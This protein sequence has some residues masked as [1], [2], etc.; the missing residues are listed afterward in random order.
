MSA[1]L[2][3]NTTKTSP[4]S[5]LNNHVKKA[6][7]DWHKPN[8]GQSPLAGL[9]IFREF[10]A[11]VQMNHRRVTNEILLAGIRR[12]EQTQEGY[13]TYLQQR[14]INE[15]S[16]AALARMYKISQ[17]VVYDRQKAALEWLSNVLWD[18]EQE[19]HQVH[20]AKMLSRLEPST[21]VNLIGAEG[22]QTHLIEKISSADAPHILLL[23]GIGGIGKTSLTDRTVRRCIEEGVVD[24][25]GWV[26][27][28][29]QQLTLL[30][31][32]EPIEAFQI[33]AH[34]TEMVVRE[35]CLQ[36]MP[37]LPL[38]TNFSLNDATKAL[39]NH[40]NQYPHLIVLDNL[41]TVEDIRGLLLLLRRLANP[42]KFL[43]TSRENLHE[44]P[45]VHHYPVPPLGEAD[46]FALIRQEAKRQA[47]TYI[48]D[49]SDEALG[50]IYETVG[51]NPLALRL[52]V[53]LARYDA[54]GD[55]LSDLKEADNQT[56]DQLY[57]YIYRHA[58]DKLDLLEKK[59][60]LTM[61]MTQTSGEELDIVVQNSGLTKRQVRESL[62]TLGRLNL[63]NVQGDLHAPR[64]SVHNL[65]LSFLLEQVSQWL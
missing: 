52:V 11:K 33:T 65:T 2:T 61:F 28:R 59:V 22:H 35:L 56:A 5:W 37:E 43:M 3:T 49:S 23:T 39:E 30:S 7:D 45:D 14:Y 29:Q 21:Y 12:L 48:V 34:T 36:L 62:R 47:M 64:Y 10:L 15:T 4:P 41:E 60:F 46:A 6:L 55:I 31:Q 42:S 24:E 44:Y 17:P 19:E 25:V 9:Y 63:V 20:Q 54:I 13:A 26:T 16:I 18:M 40:L 27:A 57:R 32:I 50:P 38:P 8:V 51:G 58:W 1:N 53:G